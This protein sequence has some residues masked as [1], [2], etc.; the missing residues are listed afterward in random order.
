MKKAEEKPTDPRITGYALSH[1]L[2]VLNPKD[3][4]E[5]RRL[6]GLTGAR[7]TSKLMFDGSETF[8]EVFRV[9]AFEVIGS[10]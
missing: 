6:L 4:E 7:F 5:L 8:G 10:K 1:R 9:D 3:A 2:K